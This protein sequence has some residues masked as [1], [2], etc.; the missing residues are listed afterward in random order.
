MFSD[1]SDHILAKWRNFCQ[2]KILSDEN[3]VRRK[4]CPT[5]IL[6]NKVLDAYGD[7]FK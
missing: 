2:T 7:Y 6:S 3:F 1:K 5:E 4:F